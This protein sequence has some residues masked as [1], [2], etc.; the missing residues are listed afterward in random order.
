MAV[1]VV[2]SSIAFLGRPP[3]RRLERGPY[4]EFG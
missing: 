2:V 4:K 1:L 3:N